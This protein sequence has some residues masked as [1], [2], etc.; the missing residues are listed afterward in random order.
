MRAF[1][2]LKNVLLSKIS[3]M[4]EKKFIRTYQRNEAFCK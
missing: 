3:T 1:V 2:I 4:T